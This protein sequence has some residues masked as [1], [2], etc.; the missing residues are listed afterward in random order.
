[1]NTLFSQ[2]DFHVANHPFRLVAKKT[3]LPTKCTFQI[4]FSV[5]KRLFKKAPDRNRIKR[6]MREVIRKNKNYL[7]APLANKNYQ[8][9]L[10]LIYTRKEIL[11]YEEFEDKIVFILQRLNKEIEKHDD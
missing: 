8:L 11:N 4:G 3:D 10:F 5:P 9:A 6:L 7:E 1:M 2:N